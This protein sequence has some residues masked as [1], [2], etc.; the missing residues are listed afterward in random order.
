MC[1]NL[2]KDARNGPGIRL[3]GERY[4]R[5]AIRNRALATMMASQ[6][7]QPNWGI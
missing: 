2:E 7:I 3:N 1:Q 6:L 5:Y 4:R